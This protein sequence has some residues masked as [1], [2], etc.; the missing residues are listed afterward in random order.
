MIK[1]I[2]EPELG[3]LAKR[4]ATIA[5]QEPLGEAPAEIANAL[6][7]AAFAV[8]A[9]AAKPRREVRLVAGPGEGLEKQARDQA[10]AGLGR[11]MGRL[12]G[13]IE[14]NIHRAAWAAASAR[15]AS[16]RS[17]PSAK[18]NS[19]ATRRSPAAPRR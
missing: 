3:A 18:R 15:R 16:S 13:R 1:V 12:H 6:L 2:S 10:I 19:R 14:G 11:V 5:A 4:S 7:P 8:T 9:A 17:M